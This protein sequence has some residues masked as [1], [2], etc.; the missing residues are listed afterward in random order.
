MVTKPRG[1]RGEVKVIPLTD[2]INRFSDLK[3]IFIEDGNNYKRL[4]V[5]GTRFGDGCAFLFL[6]TV[7]TCDE[8]EKLRGKYLCVD[9]DNAV[10]LPKDRYFIF[11]LEG[12]TVV[13]DDGRELGKITEVMQPG[14]NDVYVVSDGKNEV[15]IPAVKSFVTDVNIKEKRVTVKGQMLEEVAVYED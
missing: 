11:D 9:R 13:T 5:K 7:Y 8:A 3:Y 14:A 15:L 4:N 10:K 12:C 6:E 1:I 2:D